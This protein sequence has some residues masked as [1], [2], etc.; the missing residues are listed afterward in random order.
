MPGDKIIY[1][2]DAKELTIYPNCAD[3]KCT[4]TLPIVYG[5]LAPSEWTMFLDIGSVVDNQRAI[6]KFH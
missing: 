2:P 3:N 4:E 5:P 6:M 1:N